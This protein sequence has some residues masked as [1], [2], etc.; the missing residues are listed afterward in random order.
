MY[1]RAENLWLDDLFIF[2][3]RTHFLCVAYCFPLKLGIIGNPPQLFSLITGS[4]VPAA[5]PFDEQQG[6]SRPASRGEH[7]C[8]RSLNGSVQ[9]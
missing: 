4:I 1:I 9:L 2:S 7:W 6:A 5:A 8:P 3:K